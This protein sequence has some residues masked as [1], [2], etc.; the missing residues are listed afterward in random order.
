MDGENSSVDFR[1][2]A[3][4]FS[5]A[6][7]HHAPPI[8][9]RCHRVFL[10]AT[11]LGL[12]LLLLTAL[13]VQAIHQGQQPGRTTEEQL[14]REAV[15]KEPG[16]GD[17]TGGCGDVWGGNIGEEQL[18][19]EA[20]GKEPGMGDSTR[21]C[22]DVWGGN[23]GEEQLLREAVGKEP[24]M[25]DSTGGCGDVWGGNIGEEQLLREAVGKE[26][27][28]GDSTGGCGDVWGGNIGEEQLL[29]EAVGKEP[30]M[31]DSTRGC[32]DVWGGNIG[33]HNF[34]STRQMCGVGNRG[35]PWGFPKGCGVTEGNVAFPD[36]C[37]EE[38]GED[39]KTGANVFK[40]EIHRCG[41]Q[42]RTHPTHCPIDLVTH[43]HLWT[44]PK[45]RPIAHLTKLESLQPTTT[46]RFGDATITCGTPNAAP[47]IPTPWI[48]RPTTNPHP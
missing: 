7:R 45:P 38:R 20:V 11:A 19:R 6:E 26:P 25:G 28:M 44:P 17:S 32:G 37:Y 48:W 16:M 27:G 13:G 24:G 15:G 4:G 3:S 29:R 40:K 31:G 46:H 43:T 21:G 42:S 8:C 34:G 2:S 18:L 10:K 30:G 47:Q 41:A 5:P 12:L 23:I 35:S 9:P 36:V 39:L 22:G 33:E 1:H 14:L